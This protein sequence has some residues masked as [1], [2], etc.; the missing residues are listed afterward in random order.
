MLPQVFAAGTFSWAIASNRDTQLNPWINDEFNHLGGGVALGLRQDLA[1]PLLLSQAEK[2]RAEGETLR[3]QREGL[4]H[5]VEQQVEAAV[6]EVQ[7]AR[8]RLSAASA[9]VSSA[10]S[11]F[12]SAGL[13]FEAGVGEPKDLLD[14][15]A[16][17]IEVQVDQQQSAYDLVV[18][19]AKLDQAAG[20]VPRV[21]PNPCGPGTP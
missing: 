4:G 2:A 9:A 19:R 20:E 8:E 12:R 17:Y 10:R 5:L 13:D 1:I 15:Y 18:A 14:A 7:A 11:W 16:A 3:R 6:A 21:G